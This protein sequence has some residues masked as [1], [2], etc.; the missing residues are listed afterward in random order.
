MS[1]MKSNAPW[2]VKGI[3]RDTR[4]TAKEA[5]R[6]EG[7]TVGEWLNHIVSEV[8]KGE[9][10]TSG[11]VD[12]M[13]LR[14]LVSAI[15]H[16][17]NKIERKEDQTESGIKD[18]SRNLGGIVERIQRLERR[19]SGDGSVADSGDIADRL[20]RLEDKTNDTHRIDAL[21][22]LE[23]AVGQVAAQFDQAQRDSASRME[24]NETAIREFSERLTGVQAHVTG[25]S[26]TATTGE[27][28]D[29]HF[30]E[31]TGKRLRVLGDEIKRNG[32][33]FR[34]V[35]TQI[36]KL[37]DQIDSAE[38]R[39]S[40]EVGKISET[41]SALQ[42]KLAQ[43]SQSQGSGPS[44]DEAALRQEMTNAI[45][46]AQERSD[47]RLE[48]LEQSILD[49]GALV[50]A[51][52]NNSRAR[53]AAEPT[54]VEST[55]AEQANVE[56]EE[57]PVKRT[58]HMAATVGLMDGNGPEEIVGTNQIIE[59]F[60]PQIDLT[61][62]QATTIE[63]QENQPASAHQAEAEPVLDLDDE[64]AFDALSVFDDT[65]EENETPDHG[66]SVHVE[67]K[68]ATGPATGSLYEDDEDD[69]VSVEGSFESAF[70]DLAF[71]DP[72]QTQIQ[73]VGETETGPD[74]SLD[75][76][77]APS[78]N[79]AAID[80]GAEDRQSD[81]ARRIAAEINQLLNDVPET[82]APT[83][84]PAPASQATTTPAPQDPFDAP[85]ETI[86]EPR[87]GLS[88]QAIDDDFSFDGQNEGSFEQAQPSAV[89]HKT[90]QRAQ[91]APTQPHADAPSSEAS[92]QGV[93]AVSPGKLP[94]K[95]DGKIDIARL[96]P[97]QK[98][99]LAARAR[100]KRE[101]ALL[102]K[103]ELAAKAQPTFEVEEESPSFLSRMRGLIPTGRGRK[104]D[105]DEP[106]HFDEEAPAPAARPDSRKRQKKKADPT[107]RVTQFD[108]PAN[109]GNLFFKNR[110]PTLP[111]LILLGLLVVC[112]MTFVLRPILFGGSG[113]V[114]TPAPSLTQQ[115]SERLAP[116]AGVTPAPQPAV[117]A[118]ETPAALQDTV[119]PRQL[120]LEAMA[121]INAGD[122]ENTTIVTDAALQD[123]IKAASL[124][125]PPA[126]F[127]LGEF[128]KNGTWTDQRP[129]QARTWFQRSA[130]GGNVYA[131]HR[132]GYLYAEGEGGSPDIVTAIEWFERAANL[133]FVDSMYN[134]GAIFDPGPGNAP[135]GLQDIAKG[136]Y[137]YALAAL[138]G[139]N[140]A[141]N[142]AGEMGDRLSAEQKASV[143][144]DI[145]NW[146]T[147]PVDPSANEGLSEG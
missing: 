63:L 140:Q 127:Q 132:L 30:A 45:S 42:L 27:G 87:A 56:P 126:Q 92:S 106:A 43:G 135:Q 145:S 7:M 88:R 28:D 53:E 25:L 66:Q 67:E 86:A 107:A 54:N 52:A 58:S 12:G 13:Q 89:P 116:G 9:L 110:R 70:D 8:G 73:T 34:T 118:L 4:E 80:L 76:Q 142:K 3:A 5:A 81:D 31:R 130:T 101:A 119:R 23:R 40:E 134:L 141:G 41:V 78:E 35:E 103:Q 93:D 94:R 29:P 90:V 133:G 146:R 72:A 131:M 71:E 137:W 15:E 120:F 36:S 124:G 138:N 114:E 57:A 44:I 51:Q 61:S 18:I 104:N 46:S 62:S 112:L 33:Q 50:A 105:S 91:S 128:Y 16:L 75:S 68:V 2:S 10:Q 85:H 147:L 38:R 55:S 99:I 32:D 84:S 79:D 122:P 1:A 26:S 111:L 64:G 143:D 47:A 123:I 95:A 117:P 136:Y 39:S 24:S 113:P 48:K 19:P 20:A 108:E 49:L 83:P 109:E 97:K 98:A 74:L 144:E 121:L 77:P 96:T 125:Y 60:E 11:D 59:D 14:D 129:A 6:K 21:R 100:K 139:D 102:A 65:L 82:S 69:G 115:S 17:N 22:A 37:A